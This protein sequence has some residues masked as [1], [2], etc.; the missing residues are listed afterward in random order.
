MSCPGNPALILQIVVTILVVRHNTKI[1]EQYA[2][3]NN[4]IS[5]QHTDRCPTN[6][7]ILHWCITNKV[8]FSEHY[9]SSLYK[10]ILLIIS[11]IEMNPGPRPP[12]FPCGTCSKACGTIGII[13]SKATF[14]A[15]KGYQE[16][17]NS[18]DFDH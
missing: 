8:R 15:L 18:S 9:D 2:Y 14:T 1:N 4:D 5:F 10:S 3:I 17:E 7:G 12:K 6:I 16:Q 13:I 11:G